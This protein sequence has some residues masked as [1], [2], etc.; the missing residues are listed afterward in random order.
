MD[1]AAQ[2]PAPRAEQQEPPSFPAPIYRSTYRAML[3]E[4][5]QELDTRASITGPSAPAREWAELLSV[6]RMTLMLLGGVDGDLDRL[7]LRAWSE[8]PP[9][10]QDAVASAARALR[11]ALQPLAALTV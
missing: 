1:L 7:A 3:A 2:G 6:Y 11:R 9:T 8:I 10:E 4:L 5:R